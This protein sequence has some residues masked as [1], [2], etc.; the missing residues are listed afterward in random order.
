MKKSHTK[1]AFYV[2]QSNYPNLEEAL[3]IWIKQMRGNRVPLSTQLILK[4]ASDFAA[5]LGYEKFMASNGYFQRFKS[6]W[7]LSFAT[8]RGESEPV[9]EDVMNGFHPEYRMQ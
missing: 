4:K 2:R 3:L 9:N 8:E 6:R 7:R 1:R 5:L